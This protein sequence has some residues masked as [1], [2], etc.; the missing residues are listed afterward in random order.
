MGRLS[1]PRLLRRD[2]WRF[3]AAVIDLDPES[4]E[5]LSA[6]LDGVKE[7]EMKM[8]TDKYFPND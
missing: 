3:W 2:V 8:F 5:K 4:L 7:R 6:A 1:S